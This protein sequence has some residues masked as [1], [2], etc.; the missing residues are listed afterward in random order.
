MIAFILLYFMAAGNLENDKLRIKEYH[1]KLGERIKALRKLKGYKN[2][3]SFAYE[4]GF[5]R[6]Q[7]GRYERGSG[8]SFSTIIKIAEALDVSLAEFFKDG[9]E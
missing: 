8:I 4:H 2:H 9:F 6:A 3:E 7:F 1:L 5:A